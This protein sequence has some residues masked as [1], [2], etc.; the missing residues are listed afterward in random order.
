MSH[1]HTEFGPQE[2]YDTALCLISISTL[3]WR[4]LCLR[5]V[6]LSSS[7]LV[8]SV[9]CV[10]ARVTLY[11]IYM[12]SCSMSDTTSVLPFL[13]LTRLVL[14]QYG[15]QAPRVKMLRSPRYIEVLHVS[16]SS[17]LPFVF[18]SS[19]VRVYIFSDQVL[20]SASLS[21]LLMN[22]WA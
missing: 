13:G 3:C 15:S 12:G 21:P 5:Y 1:L 10:A 18:V 7:L 19:S 20:L 14:R 11:Y 8:V 4:R 17:I 16:M 6:R 9:K 2:H 22:M